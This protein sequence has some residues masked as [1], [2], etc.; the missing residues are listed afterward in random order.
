MLRADGHRSDIY[1]LTIDDDLAGDVLPWSREATKAAD[2]TIYHYALPSPLS[3]PFAQL[4]S[5]RVL[6]YHNVTPAHFF[7]PYDAGLFAL[8]RAGREELR[9]LAGVPDAAL[10]V[11][12]FNRTELEEM[13]FANTGV[14]PLAID[15]ARLTT[16]PDRP[17]VRALLTDDW[18]NILFVGRIAPNKKIEDHIFFAEH[19]KRYVD[20][21]YR[22]VFVG[23]Q[24]AVPAYYAMVRALIAE[25]RMRPERFVFTGPLPDADLAAVYRASHA[26]VSLSEHEGFCAP[27]AE[28]MAMDVP[29]LAYAAGAVPET[30]GGAGLMFT[31]KDFELAAELLGQVIY[32]EP[33]RR[34]VIEGQRARLPYFSANR[35]ERELRALISRFS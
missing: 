32:D 35:V 23:R 19:Y 21:R 7:A 2:V 3:A 4:S 14:L 28:A 6:L 15:L 24:D 8:S 12:N 17:A 34:R 20:E 11:S 1:S 25:F 13:G 18:A 30:L 29:V 27:L 31:V 5:G 33:L 16:A 22:F 9:G 10:G 26:Y